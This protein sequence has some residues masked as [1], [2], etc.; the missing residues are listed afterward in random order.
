M[1]RLLEQRKQTLLRKSIAEGKVDAEELENLER[2]EK[3][4]DLST[5]KTLTVELVIGGVVVLCVLSFLLLHMPKADI[6]LHAEAT[7]VRFVIDGATSISGT[8]PV[9]WI[10]VQGHN[11]AF[12]SAIGPDSAVKP[13]KDTAPVFTAQIVDTK[14]APMSLIIR[15]LP[16][17]SLVELSNWSDG[18][19]EIAFCNVDRPIPLMISSQALIQS[20]TTLTTPPQ[21]KVRVLFFPIPRD[22]TGQL[23][24]ATD[25]CQLDTMIHFRFAPA[26]AGD[27]QLSRDLNVHRLEL[28]ESAQATGQPLSTLVS[29]QYRLHSTKGSPTPLFPNDLLELGS[30]SGRM[31][32]I[33]MGDK[34][35]RFDFQG[36]VRTLTIG[37]AAMRRS[38]MPT[39]L[40]WW[41]SQE[42]LFVA[43]SAGLSSIAFLLGVYQW[44]LQRK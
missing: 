13:A 36:E 16:A 40:E 24:S 25:S 32:S 41:L 37:S 14:S 42:L 39:V 11:Q 17:G 21:S 3:L 22:V 30:P 34:A 29:G 2:L 5:A 27:F 23:A 4:Y 38:I 10:A 26:I 8:L 28:Y 15:D 33:T 6:E 35:T 31:R 9:R 12:I 1:R 43:W 20:D 7:R 44:I 19:R 18:T